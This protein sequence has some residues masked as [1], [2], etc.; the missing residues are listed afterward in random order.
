MKK[1]IQLGAISLLLLAISISS[2][3]KKAQNGRIDRDCTGT[4]LE[5]N[6]NDYFICNSEMTDSFQDGS[7]VQVKFKK[8]NECPPASVSFSCEMYHPSVGFV[9]VIEIK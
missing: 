8:L 2:C 1:N 9:E 3:R 4:Y 5:L 6:D 7:S